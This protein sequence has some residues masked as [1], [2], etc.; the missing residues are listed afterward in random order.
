MELYMCIGCDKSPSE[1]PEYVELGKD[2]GV[3]PESVV[4]SDEGT[5]N[6]K[7]GHFYCTQCYINA[8]MPLGIAK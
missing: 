4:R 3:S 6:F 7:N 1:I 2:Y 8:G 5:L